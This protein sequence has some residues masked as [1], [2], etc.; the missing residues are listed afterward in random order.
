MLLPTLQN[1]TPQQNCTPH[2]LP[3][4]PCCSTQC[5]LH[6][7][8]LTLQRLNLALQWPMT[9]PGLATHTLAGLCPLWLQSAAS[10]SANLHHTPAKLHPY[11]PP[12]PPCCR[13]NQF[14]LHQTCYA[15]QRLYLT[16]QGPMVCPEL[17]ICTL[18]GL[19]ARWLPNAASSSAKINT[20][21]KL[22]PPHKPPAQPCHSTQCRL[23]HTCCTLQRLHL[24]L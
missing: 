10:C 6:H 3:A 13:S 18:A 8:C 17:A 15:L 19:C 2:Q 21:T 7:T 5:S 1:S 22:D 4:Q 11:Q 23:H 24:T 16:L 14:R 12:F 9:C 20:P